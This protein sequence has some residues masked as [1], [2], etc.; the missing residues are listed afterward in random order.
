MA[1]GAWPFGAMLTL[2]SLCL[3][4][5]SLS[6]GL[7]RL[8]FPPQSAVRFGEQTQCFRIRRIALA[9]SLKIGHRLRKFRLLNLRFG[10]PQAARL[11]TGLP[12]SCRHSGEGK[13]ARAEDG[14]ASGW[15]GPSGSIPMR[16]EPRRS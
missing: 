11:Q 3:A 14:P 6:F 16:R 7:L 9:E 4:A 13:R 1:T 5:R 8:R 2:L 12:R 10:N 15:A